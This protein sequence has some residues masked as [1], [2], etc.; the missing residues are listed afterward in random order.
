MSYMPSDSP[1]PTKRA[2]RKRPLWRR[3]ARLL[4]A[5]TILW[6]VGTGV[7]TFLLTHR[8]SGPIPQPPPAVDWGT[9]EQV[10]L[11]TDD[12]QDIGAWLNRKGNHS[13]VVLFLH[14]VSHDR[15]DWLR[16]MQ[17]MSKQDYASMAISF[18]AHGDSTGHVEDFGY[19]ERNDVVV[20]VRYLRGQFPGRPIVLVGNS[21]GSCAAI[22]AAR[23]LG[24]DVA[25]Y[26]L[27]APFHDLLT[28]VKNR[29]DIAPPP[30]N[31]LGY[32]GFRI[33]GRILLPE[34]PTLI[35]PIDHVAEIPAD[36]PVTFIAARRDPMCKLWEVEDQFHKIEG[37]SKLVI[38]ESGVHGACR[39]SHRKQYE[40]ALF[41]LLRKVETLRG[42]GGPPVIPL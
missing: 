22:F 38:I 10:R 24:S 27:E 21:L 35:S 34:N 25:G 39:W 8:L 23:S 7:A 29:A 4:L 3:I 18:R 31:W 2:R 9:L 20:A 26:F 6:F 30:L 14:G 16:E 17:T 13:P 42:T 11:K 5:L 1:N 33:W 40:A 28:A 37:H 41:E 19:G 15:A 36:V 32:C 12:G